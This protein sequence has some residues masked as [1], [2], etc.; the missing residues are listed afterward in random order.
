MLDKFD[1]SEFRVR[2]I[3]NDLNVH[4]AC[5]PDNVSARVI[6][7]C[8]NELAHPLTILFTRSLERGVFPDRW[9]EANI[10][11]IFKKGSRKLPENYRSI[12]L[13]PLFGKILER[14]VY[15]TLLAHVRPTLT[16]KQ[17]GFVPCRSCDTNLATLLKTAW[18]SLS[19]GHQTDVIYTDYSAAFQSVNH[20]LLIYKLQRSYNISGDLPKYVC[21]KIKK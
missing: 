1:V 6:W 18:E 3:L 8:R 16:P 20:K 15:D 14:C 19:S 5:G 7:E 21:K 11:H 13:L 9:A 4:K 12:S 17:H 2:L 10:L